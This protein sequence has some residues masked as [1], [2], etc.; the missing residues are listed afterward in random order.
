[1]TTAATSMPSAQQRRRLHSIASAVAPRQ[2]A[3]AAARTIASPAASTLALFASG[4]RGLSASDLVLGCGFNKPDPAVPEALAF[5]SQAEAVATVTTALR[6]GIRQLDTAPLYGAGLSEEYIGDALLEAGLAATADL[7]IWTKV[8]V[9][10]RPADT[11]TLE[12]PGLP[13]QFGGERS[14]FRDYSAGMARR[15]LTES[16]LRLRLPTVTGLR[17]HGPNRQDRVTIAGE[18]RESMPRD[19]IEQTLEADGILA[20][21]V[22]LRCEHGS[23]VFFGLK[24]SL[25]KSHQAIVSSRQAWDKR[26]EV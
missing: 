24:V 1:M 7:K 25:R 3:P 8:G 26:K 20:G 12:Q 18:L 11:P 15:C 5:V 2:R 21:L 10:I 9:V 19:G 23:P 22:E 4:S 13:L 16:L 14:T 6:L 17:V